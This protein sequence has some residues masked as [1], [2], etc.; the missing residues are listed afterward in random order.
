MYYKTIIIKHA[1]LKKGGNREK[2]KKNFPFYVGF[3]LGKCDFL[4]FFHRNGFVDI[5]HLRQDSFIDVFRLHK[6]RKI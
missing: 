5:F 1:K 6:F 3:R 2:N 4:H